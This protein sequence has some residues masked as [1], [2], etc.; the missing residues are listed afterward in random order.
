[1]TELD[2]EEKEAN[3]P[4]KVFALKKI[5]DKTKSSD[6]CE[7]AIS[8]ALASIAKTEQNVPLITAISLEKGQKVTITVKRDDEEWKYELLC[9]TPERFKVY[10]GFTYVPD[11]LTKFD[12]YYSKEDTGSTYLITKSRRE[13]NTLRNISPTVMVTYHF[14]KK[15]NNRLSLVLRPASL[16]TWKTSVP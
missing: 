4:A 11:A 1:M 2:G 15:W 14:Y 7:S 5:I 6:S 13:R 12:N 10:F 16:T 3:I 9:P 8:K